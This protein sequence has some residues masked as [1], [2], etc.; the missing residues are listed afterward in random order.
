MPHISF[1]A[2]VLNTTSRL[3]RMCK[4]YYKLMHATGLSRFFF[5]KRYGRCYWQKTSR[6]KRG[7]YP[8]LQDFWY[9]PVAL[10]FGHSD[11]QLA[12]FTSHIEFEYVMKPQ[13]QSDKT[14]TSAQRRHDHT[15]LREYSLQ[16][17]SN[18]FLLSTFLLNR[19]S[20]QKC[21]V[22]KERMRVAEND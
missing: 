2:R 7:Y 13:E 18:F 17:S 22:N 6:C 5:N 10:N 16:I 12:A 9:A 8:Y 4:P 15:T 1:W 14:E 11:Q 20:P 19:D 21:R 3:H